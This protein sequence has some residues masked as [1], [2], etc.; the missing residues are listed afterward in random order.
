MPGNRGRRSIT[1]WSKPAIKKSK[2]KSTLNK[3]ISD[4]S[5][6][7]PDSL[8]K[9]QTCKCN[10]EDG[11]D[12]IGCYS[13]SCWYHAGCSGLDQ[14]QYRFLSEGGEEIQWVC[15]DCLA[16]KG[17]SSKTDDKLDLLLQKIEN[18]EEQIKQMKAGCIGSDLDKKIETAVEKKV[19]EV[20]D[21]KLEIEKRELNIIVSGVDEQEGDDTLTK[22]SRLLMG[23]IKKIDEDIEENKVQQITRLGRRSEG[24]N[25][26]IMLKV[27]S[28]EQKEKILRN[29]FRINKDQQNKIY[30]NPDRT[31]LQREKHRQLR[32]ELKRIRTETGNNNYVIRGYTIVEKKAPND[33]AG[34]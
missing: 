17:K 5:S 33:V 12:W 16:G 24:R 31:P 11:D 26:M 19:A 4:T 10:F 32:E 1:G 22:D 28:V 25:R 29:Y 15:Q 18:M 6:V 13:C 20:L 14:E 7:E 23:L 34:K 3:S 27:K 21:E 8:Y 9:C 2:P 30:F